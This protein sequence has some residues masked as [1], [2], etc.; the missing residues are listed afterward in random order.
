MGGFV[1]A[2]L[3]RRGH[4]AIRLAR[5]PIEGH[6]DAIMWD[7]RDP[8]PA[9][10]PHLDAVIHCAAS[11]A[12]NDA[13]GTMREAHVGGIERLLAAWPNA[14]FVYVSSA[15][16]Y[17]ASLDHPA[18]I[19]DATG[20]G[21][22]DDYARTK[23]AAELALARQFRPGATVPSQAAG[24]P[25][26]RSATILRPTIIHGPGDRTVLPNLRRMR[27]GGFAFVPGGKGMWTMTPVT[28]LA[29]ACIAAATAQRPELRILNVATQPPVEIGRF[30]VELLEEDA[31]RRLRI[32]PIPMW[33]ALA[34]TGVVAGIW[35]L[36]RI[37]RPT[38]LTPSSLAYLRESRVLDTA[39][40]EALVHD[41]RT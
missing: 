12:T 6:P 34:F 8:A 15:S 14:T 10:L 26:T 22:H 27:V 38:L 32:V 18:L 13:D 19:E 24:S 17:P 11:V 5:R 29:D 28:L 31:G 30:L 3:E 39:G 7:L 2:E 33:V 25:G 23:Y 40:L 20:A 4:L 37:K 9:D 1:A 41:A 36:F 21:Q 35:K 16:V